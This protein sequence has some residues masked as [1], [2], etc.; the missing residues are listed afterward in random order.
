MAV[1]RWRPFEDTLTLRQAMDRLFEDSF[2]RSSTGVPGR[3]EAAQLPANVWEDKDAVHVVARVPGLEADD[4]DIQLTGDTLTIRG[5]FDSDAER[6]EGKDW[7]WYSN[8]LWYGPFE[9][10][11]TLPTQVQGDKVEAVFKNGVL[12]LTVPK[13]EEVKPKTIKVK[14]AS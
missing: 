3:G 10:S 13:A 6:E 7:S 11:I 5:R 4:L 12:H 14:V 1:V 8:E 2:V 9:R